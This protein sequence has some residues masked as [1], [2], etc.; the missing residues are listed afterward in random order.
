MGPSEEQET[1]KD[2]N[3]TYQSGMNPGLMSDKPQGAGGETDHHTETTSYHSNNGEI[4]PLR[5][6]E[7]DGSTALC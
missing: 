7:W 5:F 3:T 4:V 1:V 2:G 6:R